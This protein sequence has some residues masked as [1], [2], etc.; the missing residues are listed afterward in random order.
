MKNSPNTDRGSKRVKV[1][2]IS[3]V[4]P[5]D[6]IRVFHKEARTLSGGGYDVVL[7]A[8]AP[9]GQGALPSPCTVATLKSP[10][11][12]FVRV[13][14]APWKALWA[15]LKQNAEIYHFHDPELI[16]I[17][18]ILRLIGKKVVYDVHEDYAGS[19]LSKHYLMPGLRRILAF[20]FDL[21]EKKS[22]PFFNRV[23]VATEH[24]GKKF[25]KGKTV[26]IHNYPLQQRE[27]PAGSGGS[28]KFRIIYPGPIAHIRGIANVVDAVAAL[29]LPDIEL[30]LIGDFVPAQYRAELMRSPGW[31]NVVCLGPLPHAEV[32]EHIAVSDLGIECSLPAPNYLYSESNKV[33]EYMSVG[34]PVLCSNLPRIQEIVEGSRC[35]LCVDPNSPEAI[36]RGIRRLYDDPDLRA[37]MG[38]NGRRAISSTYNWDVEGQRLLKVYKELSAGK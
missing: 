26:P 16:P 21:V 23:I 17:G 18:L 28:G 31:R 25:K 36:A 14:V 6:D 2:I 19:I 5:V 15:G 29:G 24:I 9:Q 10:D 12:K 37:E 20:L 7:L 3:T 32:I 22:A 4:H 30:M 38:A 27:I 33:F 1:C 13:V 35:G 11:N 8:L 34:I